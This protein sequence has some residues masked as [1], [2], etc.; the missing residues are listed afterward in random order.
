MIALVAG[1]RSAHVANS[2]DT[3]PPATGSERPS[4]IPKLPTASPVP[5]RSSILPIALRAKTAAS[6]SRATKA[7]PVTSQVGS[8]RCGERFGAFGIDSFDADAPACSGAYPGMAG[9]SACT[10]AIA[11]SAVGRIETQ[12][13]A[14]ATTID[15]AAGTNLLTGSVDTRRPC[16][17]GITARSTVVGVQ[18]DQCAC[19]TTFD[20]AAGTGRDAGSVLADVAGRTRIVALATIGFVGAQVDTLVAT[21]DCVCRAVLTFAVGADQTIG[22]NCSAVAAVERIIFYAKANT[23]AQFLS[24]WTPDSG[25]SHRSR[26]SD[27]DNGPSSS[28]SERTQERAATGPRLSSAARKRGRSCHCVKPSAHYFLRS[29]VY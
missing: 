26:R 1:T 4:G 11:A 16:R 3:S 25:P 7:R 12:V 29:A 23:V 6:T 19:A 2:A 17:A 18:Q 24:S 15:L 13:C 8:V 10:C 22:T 5:R 27:C 28:G 21:G 9:L 20:L 14:V